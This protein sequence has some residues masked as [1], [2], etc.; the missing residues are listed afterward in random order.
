MVTRCRWAANYEE[1]TP[2]VAYHDHE[3]GHPV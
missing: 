3:F 2:M 1:G